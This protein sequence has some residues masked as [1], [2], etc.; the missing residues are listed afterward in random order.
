[1]N[2]S[3][4]HFNSDRGEEG[5]FLPAKRGKPQ[6]EE[7][8]AKETHILV[9][10]EKLFSITRERCEGPD[11]RGEGEGKGGGGASLCLRQKEGASYKKS[12]R[13]R[14]RERKMASSAFACH[15]EKREI[16]DCLQGKRKGQEGTHEKKGK[17]WL[18]SA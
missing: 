8:N 11:Q 9:V 6:R 14:E 1:V 17:I 4:L 5:S 12:R 7:E 10:S 13:R 3:F 16:L 2:R 18:A 15:P